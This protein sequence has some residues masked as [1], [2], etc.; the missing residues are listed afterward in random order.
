M[1]DDQLLELGASK[2]EPLSS[3]LVSVLCLV[4]V[5]VGSIMGGAVRVPEVARCVNQ[6]R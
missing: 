5:R 1:P 4:L 6:R 2:T 3:R